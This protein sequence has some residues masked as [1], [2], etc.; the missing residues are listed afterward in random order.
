MSQ[1]SKQSASAPEDEAIPASPNQLT[2]MDDIDILH[3][4][5]IYREFGTRVIEHTT[6]KGVV[7]AVRASETFNDSE[8]D[9]MQC[10]ATHGVLAPKVR[11][12]YDI[13]NSRTELLARVM[14]SERVPG[15]P[16]ADAWEGYNDADKSAI[17]DQL[18]H[19]LARIRA[20]TQPY[21]GR[22]GYQKLRNVYDITDTFCG[23]FDTEK[24]FDDFCVKCLFGGFRTQ[25]KWKRFL[26]RDRKQR[27]ST[28]VLT[29]G[30]LTPG[31]IIVQGNVITGIIDWEF[32]GFCPEYAEYAIALGL[33]RWYEWWTPVLAEI[34]PSC[35][36]ERLEFTGMIR[37]GLLMA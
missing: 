18:R 29:H 1:A 23:P 24:A 31:N 36:A 20:C 33:S 19:Q 5:E 34:L 22:I 15:I 21:I 35:P 17:K 6:S 4:K 7:L 2:S 9:M 37:Y 8:A 13:Y 12:I 10:A 26:R 3:G 30:D 11:G 27:S 28:F 32:S 14:V 16:L 25:W